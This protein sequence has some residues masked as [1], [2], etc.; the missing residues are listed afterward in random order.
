MNASLPKM[1]VCLWFDGQAEQ[2]AR[3]YCGIFRDAKVL[4]TT[5][6][7]PEVASVSGEPEGS[8]MSV[9]FELNGLLIVALNGGRQVQFNESLSIMVTCENQEEVDHYWSQLAQGGD[10]KAQACGWLK[11]R[12]GVSWQIVPRELI[13]IETSGDEAKVR[14]AMAAILP[15][16]KLEVDGIRRAVA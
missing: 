7:T 1:S 15:M 12:F 13:E 8:V 10:A 5:Q 6:V 14:K 4:S 2:A 11:D 9:N 16:K 3:F